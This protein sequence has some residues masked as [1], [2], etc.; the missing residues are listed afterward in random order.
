M[1]PDTYLEQCISY[2]NIMIESIKYTVFPAS[3]NEIV[4]LPHTRRRH[5]AIAE[6]YHLTQT[7]KNFDKWLYCIVWKA[8]SFQDVK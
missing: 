7:N 4:C 6:L 2:P 5:I 1:E 8:R 3:E